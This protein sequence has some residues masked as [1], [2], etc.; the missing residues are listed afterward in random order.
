MSIF[1]GPSVRNSDYVKDAK[2]LFLL[3]AEGKTDAIEL[4]QK[5]FDMDKKYPNKGWGFAARTI[6]NR[7][8]KEKG[9]KTI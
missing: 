3:A 4:S 9:L 5:F 8:A 6:F 2:A 7:M 1:G